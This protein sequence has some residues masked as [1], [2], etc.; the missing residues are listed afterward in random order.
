MGKL[1]NMAQN[2]YDHALKTRV[3]REITSQTY[4]QRPFLTFAGALPGSSVVISGGLG[5]LGSLVG[6]WA[7]ASGANNLTLLGRS[8]SRS[9]N[10]ALERLKTGAAAT[11]FAMC[12]VSSAEDCAGICGDLHGPPSPL[13]FHAGKYA[14]YLKHIVSRTEPQV[15]TQKYSELVSGRYQSHFGCT[16]ELNYKRQ[17]K[18]GCNDIKHVIQQV[19]SSM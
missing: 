8:V 17:K 3:S 7:A 19:E 16:N 18:S 1:C 6:S 2:T 5:A 11:T 14:I 13:F 9:G 12:D 10:A 15:L 4:S